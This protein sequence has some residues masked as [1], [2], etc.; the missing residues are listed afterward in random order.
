M[1]TT[2]QATVFDIHLLQEQIC[3]YLTLRDIR[4]CCLVSKDFYQNFSPYLYRTIPIHRKSTFN[5]FHRPESLAALARYHDKVIHVTSEFAQIWKTLLDHQCH[6][7]VTLT[8]DRLPRRNSNAETNKHQT[9][10]IS[11]LI[12]VN[13]RLYSVQLGQFLFEPEVISR[14]CSVLRNHSRIRELSIV[15]PA[16]YVTYTSIRLFMWSSFRLERLCLKVQCLYS[17]ATEMT[18]NQFQEYLDL[19]GSTS[20]VFAL[21]ELSIPISLYLL[22]GGAFI[23]FLEYT[24]HVERFVAPGIMHDDWIE[25]LLSVMRRRMTNI[26]HLNICSISIQ[27]S[28]VAQIIPLCRNLKSF[29]SSSRLNG[30]N[31]IAGALL[32]HHRETLEEVHMLGAGRMTSVQV[33]SFLTECPKLQIFD[34]MCTTEKVSPDREMMTRQRIGDAILSTTDMNAAAI[35]WACAGLKV[36]KLRYAVPERA[37]QD[38]DGDEEQ[39]ESEE[40]KEWVLPKAL[41]ERIAELTELEILWL[42][43]VE[44][45]FPSTD[46]F[47]LALRVGRGEPVPELDLEPRQ[48]ESE[49]EIRQYEMGTLNVSKALMAW[50]SLPKLR[51]LHLRGL[52]NFIDKKTVREARRSW[53]NLDW[54][55]YQ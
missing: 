52:K 6:N 20:P 28:L 31:V 47:I 48:P 23:R 46:S 7:L 42:G 10:Y 55:W 14:F 32:E 29:V 4:R 51:Q 36:L 1:T 26:Q 44:P 16:S 50:R 15:S 11:D 2:T 9:R 54:I 25:G 21:R 12:E 3:A 17:S 5:K 39:E 33:L 40:S 43:R 53:K 19:T 22:E 8:S 38:N 49:S 34:A 35:P 30:I 24:P 45:A 37:H 18:D 13:P 27:G 41:Y